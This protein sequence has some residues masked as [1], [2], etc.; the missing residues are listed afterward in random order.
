[1]MF[2]SQIHVAVKFSTL[3]SSN[4]ISVTNSRTIP[5]TRTQPHPVHHW[6][7]EIST[8]SVMP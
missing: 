7:T 2:F 8:H 5:P 4:N 1:M 3:N 6:L